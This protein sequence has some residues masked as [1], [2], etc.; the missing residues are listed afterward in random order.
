MNKRSFIAGIVLGIVVTMFVIPFG[1]KL[2]F[3]NMMFKEVPSSFGFE[4]TVSLIANR[5]DNQ[6]GWHVT[7]II[8]QEKV[9]LDNGGKEVGKVKIIKFCNAKLSSKMLKA[10]DRKYMSV[11]MPLSISVYEKSD[12]KVYIGLMNGYMMTRMMSGTKEGII[13]ESVVK[14]IENIMSFLHFRYTIF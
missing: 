10:D 3:K 8:N 7:D 9:L 5:I 2:A 6:K 1:F 11:K 4:K 14:D 13:M 12:G